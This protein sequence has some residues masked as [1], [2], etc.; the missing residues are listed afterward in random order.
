MFRYLIIGSGRWARHLQK[1]LALAG[2]PFENWARKTHS[3]EQL[4]DALIRCSHVWLALSDQA[5]QEWTPLLR[6]RARVLIH[7]SG[8]LEIEGAHS[9][10]PLMSF[11][12]ELYPDE[13]YAKYA[14]VTTSGLE[15]EDLIP[16]LPNAL[17]T[18]PKEKKTFYHALCVLAGNGSVLLWRKFFAEMQTLGIP[19]APARLY[20][21]RILGNLLERPETALTGPLVR[22]DRATL[23]MD[24]EALDHDP[25]R[26]VLAAMIEAYSGYGKERP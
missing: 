24:L 5:L 9:V 8:A 25:Y 10:H 14:F 21:E 19:G 16:G 3:R 23:A 7:S 18:I 2:V 20:A 17:V 11:P 4:D 22:N 13:F 12:P 15:R 6:D 1:S 26:G